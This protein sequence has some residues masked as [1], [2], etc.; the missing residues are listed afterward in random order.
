MCILLYYYNGIIVYFFRD[1]DRFLWQAVDGCDWRLIVINMV[2]LTSSSKLGTS[3]KST[4]L[5]LQAI[6]WLTDKA[7]HTVSSSYCWKYTAHV[8][9]RIESNILTYHQYHVQ[10][11]PL[12]TSYFTHYFYPPPLRSKFPSPPS[13]FLM[14]LPCHFLPVKG[15][16]PSY[17]QKK[18]QTQT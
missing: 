13:T 3:N 16:I 7:L 17:L 4:L 6:Y 9:A 2:I 14:V 18:H 15:A 12:L 11:V 5:H 1:A 10:Y 8:S